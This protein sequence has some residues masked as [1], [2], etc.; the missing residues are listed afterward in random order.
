MMWLLP[1]PLQP[2]SWEMQ[3]HAVGRRQQAG[4]CSRMAGSKGVSKLVLKIFDKTVWP[5]RR[6][7]GLSP[8]PAT[9]GCGVNNL[10]F[11]SSSRWR[12]SA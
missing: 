9:R 12:L 2:A 8:S 11:G 10:Q 4:I 6:I 1:T 7:A 3:P 5:G